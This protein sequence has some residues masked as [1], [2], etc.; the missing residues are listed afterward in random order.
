M[1]VIFSCLAAVLL[2]AV[3]YKPMS[4]ALGLISLFTSDTASQG[5]SLSDIYK[6][7]AYT[8]A[9]VDNSS[10]EIPY[11]GAKY[12]VLECSTIGLSTDVYYGDTDKCLLYGAGTYPGSH[13]PGYGYPVLIAGHA[14]TIFNPLK[15]SAVGDI[16]TLTTNY[17]VYKYQV[18]S[19]VI[20]NK[21]DFD[22][23]VLYK[24]GE[25]LI[26]YTCYPFEKLAGVKQQRLFLYCDL[27]SGPKVTGVYE[28][29]D[30][31]D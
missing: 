26:L 24:K 6:G 29:G 19:R 23:S 20:I 30:T 25:K 9:T 28:G 11:I 2:I 17:G 12:A 16:F 22:T 31:S 14:Q 27:I 10:I 4:G 5:D 7:S 8:G 1:P 3:L 18:T 21:D 15:D 13:L